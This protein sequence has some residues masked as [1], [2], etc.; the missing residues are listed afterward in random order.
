MD[1]ADKI[2]DVARDARDNPTDRIEMKVKIET[3]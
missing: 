3:R 2:V 1:V